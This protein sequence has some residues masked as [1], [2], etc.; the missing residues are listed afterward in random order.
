MTVATNGGEVRKK[1]SE[2]G[3]PAK[4]KTVGG[5]VLFYLGWG[6]G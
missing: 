6:Y 4:R 3:G 1:E 2:R 5:F